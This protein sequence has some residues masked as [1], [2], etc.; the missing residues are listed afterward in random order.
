MRKEAF[1]FGFL[2]FIFMNCF[3]QDKTNPIVYSEMFGGY[4]LGSSEGWT[5]GLN[6][7]YQT[8][9]N[10]I[11]GRYLGLTKLKHI[12]DFFIFP[13]YVTVESINEFAVLYGKRFVH[14]GHS[15]SYSAGIAYIDREFMI[16]HDYNNIVYDNQQSVGFPFEINI[17]WFKSKKER[18]RV[19][20]GLIP[21]GKP[22]SFG[23]SIGFK[24]YGDISK[25]TFVGLGLTYGLG[26]HKNY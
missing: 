1:F 20:Y 24:F 3:G 19:M 4:S 7:N 9:N 8:K 6:I 11:T 17:K 16:N 13:A 5:G 2:S 14:K 15:L 12:G 23:R 22:T 10:L 26:W 21:I 25:T 18:F